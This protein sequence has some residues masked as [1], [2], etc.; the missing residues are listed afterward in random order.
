MNSKSKKPICLNYSTELKNRKVKL[1]PFEELFYYEWLQNPS[2]SDYNIIMDTIVTGKMSEE[3]VRESFYK[4]ITDHFVFCSNPINEEDGFYWKL[5]DPLIPEMD[6]YHHNL[7]DLEI[8][9]IVST[10]FNIEKDQLIKLNVIKI[11]EGRYR[12][13]FVISHLVIDGIKTHETY[14]KWIGNFNYKEYYVPT[15]QEQADLHDQ[16]N[17][18]FSNILKKN[19][20]KIHDFWKQHLEDVA[21]IDLAFLKSNSIKTPAIRRQISEFIF[22]Y[23]ETVVE[24]LKSLRHTYK[25]TPYIFGQ[26]VLAVLLNKITGQKNIGISYPI[27]VLEG[28][29]LIYGAHVNTLIIDYRFNENTNIAS[30]IEYALNFFK[31][32]K[33]TKA[34][35]LPIQEIAQYATNLGILELGFAQTFL[36]DYVIDLEGLTFERVNHEFQVDL[37][38]KLLF[39]QEQ[40]ENRLNY[41]VKY[42]KDVLDEHLVMNFV[43][44]Y[45]NLFDNMLEDLLNKRGEKDINSYQ[46][47]DNKEYNQ[48]IHS[49]NQTRK[50]YSKEKSLHELFEEQVN[51]Y[52]DNT[53]LIYGNKTLT[54]R[55]LNEQANRLAHYLQSTYQ[56]IPDDLI[57]LCL[58][59]SEYMLIS[60][61][62]I[63]KS[64]AGYIPIEPSMPD[65]RITY[66]LEDAKVKVL[67]TDLN[68][69]KRLN[70]L[71]SNVI[72]I[73]NELFIES[74]ELLYSATNP[75]TTVSSNNIAYVIYTSGTTGKPKGVI[76]EHRNVNR[77]IINANYVA[78]DTT[79][80]ILS[81]SGYQFDGSIYDFFAPLLNGASLVISTK[82]VFLDLNELN[83]LIIDNKVTNFLITT[84]L[85]NSIVDANLSGI[86][87]LKYLLFGGEKVSINHVVKFKENFSNVNLV[88]VYGPTEATTYATGYLV[89]SN[90]NSCYTVP[91]GYPISNTSCYV[92]DENLDPLPVGA[93]GELYIGGAGVARG[94]LNR[95]DLTQER[96]LKNPFQTKEEEQE[97]YNARIY[98]TGDL[99]RYL[100]DGAIEYVGRNDFQIKIRGFRI[101]LG[102]IENYLV[103]IPDITQAIVIAKEHPSGTKYLVAYYVSEQEIDETVIR[104]YLKKNLPEYMIPAVIKHMTELPVNING[105]IDRKALPEV[106]F[107]NKATYK[108]P[109]NKLE[110][111]LCQIYGELLELKP[112]TISVEDDFYKLGGN[113][114]MAIKL[115][116]KIN[117]ELSQ[118]IHVTS[119]FTYKTIRQLAK[120]IQQDYGQAINITSRQVRNPEEQLLS[121]AQERLWFIES[122]ESGSNAY[123]I[124][125]H[126]ELKENT[127]IPHLEKAIRKVIHRHEVLRSYI[128]TGTDG[129]GYQQIIDDESNPISI[130]HKEVESTTQLETYMAEVANKIFDLEKEYPICIEFYYKNKAKQYM[131][132]VVHHIAFDGWSGEIFLKEVC[133]YYNYYTKKQ[134]DLTELPEQSIQYKDFAL[135]Q[136]SYLQ[137]E[138]LGQQLQFW[139]E[140]LAGYE[141]L[142]LPVDKIRPT[143]LDYQGS[144]IYFTLE[145]D[146][147]QKLREKAKELNVSMYSMLLGGYYLLLSAYSN[148]KDI[149]L[150]T[151]IA[152]R[153]YPEIAE[154]IGFF[155]NTLAIRQQIEDMETIASFIRKIGKSMDIAQEN[156]DL[157]F[158]KLVEELGVEKDLSRHPVF[159]VMF[160]VQSFGQGQIRQAEELMIP[161]FGSGQEKQ[162]VAKFDITTMID[163][164][165]TCITGSFNYA[166]SIFHP[167]TI[168]QYI[169]TYKE[170]LK[171]FAELS[172]DTIT[173]SQI[174]L[175]SIQDFDKIVYQWNDTN[176]PFEEDKTIYQLFEEQAEKTPENIAVIYEDRKL[177]YRQLNEKSNQ[178][179]AYL[180]EKYSI[181]PEDMIGVCLNRSEYMIITILGVLKAGAAYVP[182]DPTMPKERIEYIFED[183]R[184]KAILTDLQNLDYLKTLAIPSEAINDIALQQL[185]QNSYS[186]VNLKGNSES[187][188]LAYVIYTSGTTGKPKGVMVE[189]KSVNR[190]IVNTNYVSID[191]T[192]NILSLSG[193]QFDGS[194][195]DFFAPLL[196]GASL[197]ISVKEIFLDF[198]E[199]NKIILENKINNFF[200]TTSLFNSIVEANLPAIKSL[201]YILYGGEK[202]SITHINKFKENYPE[203]KLLNVYG[204]TET[205]TFAT[206]YLVDSIVDNYLNLPIGRPIANTTTY[207]LDKNLHPLPIGAVGELY[208]GGAGV[209]RGYLNRE[210]LTQER[211]IKNPF[212]TEEEKEKGYNSILYKTGDLVRYLENGQIE[213]IGRNDFQVKIR[214]FRIEL[215]EIETCLTGYGVIK[216]AVVLAKEHHSGNKYLVG[217]YVSD[218]EL[219]EV[220]LRSYLEKNLPEFM[221]PTVLIHLTEL[222]VT[223][224]GKVD[225]KALPEPEFISHSTYQAPKNETE[226]QLCKI[227]A[228]VLGL[229]NSTIS[230]EDDFFK[231]G[232]D[233]ISSIQL[234]NRIRQR[235]DVHVEVKDIFTHSTIKSLYNNII[236]KAQKNNQNIRSEQGILSGEFNL[237]P[238]QKWFFNNIQKGLLPAYNHWNQ[239]FILK[240][241][242]LNKELLYASIKKVIEH[243]DSFRLIYQESPDTKDS[244]K[245][246]YN[247]EM[248]DFTIEYLNIENLTAEEIED[249]LT[250]WQA[251]FDITM[252]KIFHIGCLEEQEKEYM[253]IH[254]AMHHLA[255]DAVSWR[256]IKD[257][258]ETIYQ[259]LSNHREEDPDSIPVSTI[260]GEKGSSY[261]QWVESITNYKK[262]EPDELEKE[263]LYWESVIS[264][265]TQSNSLFFKLET[266]QHS[267]TELI[268]NKSTTRLLLQEVNHVCN[269][270][271]NDILLTALSQTLTEFTGSP[272]HHILLEGHGREN[273]FSD[274]NINNTV[275]WFTSMYPVKIGYKQENSIAALSFIKDTL[276]QIPNKGI[277]YGALFGYADRELPTVCFNYLG[278]FDTIEVENGMQW[279]FTHENSGISIATENKDS[280]ALNIN[281]GIIDNQLLF[282][283]SGYLSTENLNIITSTFEKNLISLVQCLAAENRSYLTVADTEFIISPDYLKQIQQKNEIENIYLANSLQEGFIYHATSQGEVDDAYRVHLLWDYFNPLEVEVLKSAWQLAQQKFE[284]LRLRFA[285]DE[286]L[287]QIVDKKGQ[288][289]WFYQDI[290]SLSHNEKQ[291]F[292]NN[293]VEENRALP[294][295]LQEGS[296]F[297][298]HLIKQSENHYSALFSNH[299]AILDGWS[300]MILL[301]YVHETY[302]KLIKNQPVDAQCDNIYSISQK[303]LQSH[304][305]ENVAYWKQQVNMLDSQEDLSSL[306][307]PEL[308]AKI[309]LSEYKHIKQP[310]EKAICIDNENYQKIKSICNENGF[311]INALL[312]YC[313][314]RQLNIYSASE[315]T[316]VGTVVSGRNLSVDGIEQSVGLYINTLPVIVDH[317]PQSVIEKIRQVQNQ[318][319]EANGKSDISLAILQKEGKR[320]FNTLFVFENY[321]V[322]RSKESDEIFKI[323]LAKSIEKLDYPLGITVYEREGEIHF[324]IRYA[325]ELF[326]D[327]IID[328]LLDGITISIKEIITKGDESTNNLTHLSPNQY[329]NIVQNWNNTRQPF[330]ANKTINQLFEEQVKR[331]PDNIAVVYED[332]ALTYQELNTKANQLGAYLKQQYQI[333]PDDLIVLCLDRSYKMLISMLA[334]MKSGAAYVPVS[335]EYP[336]E[337]IGFVL[338]DTRAKVIITNAD[339]QER[340][341]NLNPE[342]SILLIE[343]EDIWESYSPANFETSLRPDNLAYVIYTSGT[344]GRPKGVLIEHRNLVHLTHYQGNEFELRNG[345]Q[346]N[347]LWYANY[348]FDA[349]IW[350]LYVNLIFG[351]STFIVPE[352][353]R[354]DLNLLEQ[355]IAEN[356]IYLA[357]IPPVLLNTTTILKLNT[358]VVA[359]EV[360]NPEVMNAYNQHGVKII[361]AYGP[362]ETT[363]CG[364][365]HVFKHGDSNTNIGRPISNTSCYVLDKTLNPLPVGAIGELYIG[366]A[367]VARGYL[368]REELTQERFL[369]N[370]FQTQEEEQEGYNDRIYKTGDLVRYLPDGSIEY[371]GRNDFQVKIRGFRIELGEIENC[372]TAIPDITQATVIAKEHPSGTKF[373]VGYYVSEQEKDEV[374]IREHMEKN[375]PEYMVPAVIMHLTEMPVTI[376]GKLDRK[377]LPEVEFTNKATYKAP[378]NKLEEELC[379]IYAGLLELKPDTISV[380]DDFYKL[381]GNS[382]LAIKLVSRINKE[383]SQNIHVTAVFTHKTIR[384]LARHIQLDQ[385][386]TV[387]ITHK[388]VE[389]PEEQLL[390]FA[391]ERLWFIESFEG[392]SNAY[393]IPIHF[394]LQKDTEIHHLIQAIRKVVHRHEV[395]RSYIWTGTEGT[396]YQLVVD[397][398]NQPLII[399]R[400]EVKD[401][402]QLEAYM[403]E[404]TNRI[405]DLE[406]EY[407]IHIE[408][409]YSKNGKRYLTIVVHH[410]AFDGWSAEVFM[411]EVCHYYNYY[412]HTQKGL[413]ELP[414]VSIQYKDFALWQRNYLQGEILEQQLQFWKKQLEGYET[415]HL[416]TDKT[417]PSQTDYSGSEI[418]FTLEEGIS[419]KLRDK[420]KELNVSMYSLLL[421]GYYLLLSAYSNQKDI[422]IGSP[423]AGRHYPEIT[424]TIGFFVNTL[425]IRQQ[426]DDK[427]AISEFIRRIGK[428][429]DRAQ[430]N[431]DLPFE[432]LV[433]ELDVEKDLSRHPIF[434]VMFSVQSFGQGQLGQAEELMAPYQGSG[435]EKQQVAKFDLTTMIDDAQACIQGSFNYATSLF[436]P[437]TIE[438][439][440]ETYKEILRQFAELSLESITTREISFLNKQE[441]E[442]IIHQWNETDKP[443]KKEKTIH[444]MFEEQVE[445]TPEN[446]AVIY[447]GKKLTYRQLN[448]K[449]NQLATYLKD[450]Y[451]I[452]P[453]ELI[454]L[455]LDRSEYMLVAILGVLKAG[456][457]YVPVDP[458]MPKE[459]IEYILHDIHT[460][461]L[462]TNQAYKER[463]EAITQGMEISVVYPDN[464]VFLNEVLAS[465]SVVN[466]PSDVVSTNLAYVI[467]TSG[468]T[469]KPKGAMIEHTSVINRITWMHEQY[470][471]TPADKI[472]QKTTYTFDVSVWELFWANW[473]GAT[474]VF[475]HP[476]DYKDNLYLIDLIKKE[477]ITT[478]HFVP[479]MLAAFEESLS[480]NLH[481]KED[482]TSLRY[483]FCSGEALNLKEVQKFKELVPSCEIHNLYGPTEATVDVLYYDCNDNNLSKVLIGR[484]IYNTTAYI[485][486]QNLRPLPVGASGELYIGGVNVGRGYLNNP[487]LTAERFLPNPFQREEEKNTGSNSRI[488]KTGDVVR[489]QSDGNIEY[490]GRNDFQV[491]IRGFRI[492]LEEIEACMLSHTE[493]RQAIV[494]PRK[495]AAGSLY[496]AGY[497]LSDKELDNESI[498]MH[499]EKTLPEYMVPSVFVHLT[500][501][502][503]TPNGKLDRKALPEPEFTG[504]HQYIAPANDTERQLCE[505]YGEVLGI[506]P[507]TISASDDFYGL[508]GNSI[509]TIR[510][511]H[512]INT[513]L[514]TKIRL[515]DILGPKSIQS[516]STTILKSSSHFKPVV[517]LNN[518]AGK[519][520]MFMVHPGIA[521]CEVYATLSQK[522]EPYYHCKGID[523]YNLYHSD[524]IK[525]LDL[526]AA[527]YLA[528]IDKMKDK[529]S[530]YIFLGWSLGGQIALE[531][532]AQLEARGEKNITVYLL[533]TWMAHIRTA[534]EEDIK[535]F[536]EKFNIPESNRQMILDVMVI[537]DILTQQPLS[538]KLRYTNVVLFKAMENID[539]IYHKQYPYNNIDKYLTSLSQIKRIDMPAG[540]HSLMEQN[541]DLVKHLTQEKTKSLFV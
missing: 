99:V 534:G 503:L 22:R 100:P 110:E 493:I 136:R 151:P 68:N 119:V 343:K 273:I 69:E 137:G 471:I 88:H 148:Q 55:D 97:E 270:E 96:F 268:F 292:I 26:L 436:S 319:N 132:I 167:D 256:I 277:G 241:P 139:K 5:R 518:A 345:L 253:G 170:I 414:E 101:E 416:P 335:P 309:V 499:L 374:S 280:Y 417:R 430:E 180:K 249:K 284:T 166:T 451:Q 397:D 224:N 108:A 114:I 441:F 231:L 6:F 458:N 152:G 208:I 145:E 538:G 213:Y 459:R 371:V 446:I 57:G 51:K 421:G 361:N 13:I 154:T 431:Q 452:R 64:G 36:R 336:D 496:L 445:R 439:Y 402:E 39:E 492:E 423:I 522:L 187:A 316:V 223:I 483:L 43:S 46:L 410:I 168:K 171:Q 264:D 262:S 340:I 56:I 247:A 298:I 107:T 455:C 403:M 353:Y 323:K 406:N 67:L 386:Q 501:I 532:A 304:R 472:L 509:L 157:P 77:L 498:R 294:F 237:L 314:H 21:G 60:I 468:T 98:K 82:E 505:I 8:Y 475:A 45:R 506:D 202:A 296:L 497:Y 269:T 481:L 216:Q 477:G 454:G 112:D 473:Y 182:V 282:Y 117:K 189:H 288:F 429:M 75:E 415:L 258:L 514:Q 48:I 367:G 495:Q 199:L 434:Q 526:L 1:T 18:V 376:N 404:A 236:S 53:A 528:A 378:E 10:P 330:P 272:Y 155:V 368:N 122:F 349:H 487:S 103:N 140:Q 379:Q 450:T 133:H 251:N 257:D 74:L 40:H 358:L 504:K 392:G 243:H 104:E 479:S 332:I 356:N 228:D 352:S 230:T 411:R 279:S 369:K 158:E 382:I 339:Y 355:Y 486:D 474:I 190:L 15:F 517:E 362:T 407:P 387:K 16:L 347:C 302:I 41:R 266:G 303:Y 507:S 66:M 435:Q 350:E 246:I 324:S 160:S 456:A 322:S 466:N 254:F 398:E 131:N 443:F 512:K 12:I 325:S 419:Q 464:E 235:L 219:D 156:Q 449:A 121:F 143:Q 313:W 207:I 536:M 301:N 128:Q 359:G 476:Q 73:N 344:T 457:A 385:R 242:V 185:L 283:V 342:V 181:Q 405:F 229:N 120:H 71:Y 412:T 306:L 24:K 425:A 34:K 138:I 287:V 418:C 123:N 161:Y 463:M 61:L 252:G 193:Y 524:K 27:A 331:T 388:Q 59:R 437:D 125:I 29:D 513:Q 222:P 83:N 192:D 176:R 135:W 20:D 162:Q 395:L 289:N 109:E 448:E 409:Y 453:D 427:E 159:Q 129:K 124:P 150:G 469:G 261:R 177:T 85:F 102:E 183:A 290:S 2:R 204:P 461:V 142:H 118:N 210:E 179:A 116:S 305:H 533:D 480:N 285:W 259:Y 308:K 438:R 65:E 521:G 485:L 381:G 191:E 320:L 399:T 393:N 111:Q 442:Q 364:T 212:Q 226:K 70:S 351:H 234:V 23:D 203:V 500:E 196:N 311:T 175:L 153:H 372:L 165:Q 502:P 360:T 541:D 315:T 178:L 54:Y 275:G 149:I 529:S 227:Y 460:K 523:S 146:V 232:G 93:I 86:S 527:Y 87:S 310:K 281:G 333:Q 113:S 271:I 297:R 260:L 44:M 274:I 7:A 424:E 194:I 511:V 217:Y 334:V 265:I 201:K 115:V 520:T 206:T 462:L 245:Q 375:L 17:D 37:V 38:N 329:T 221:I 126:F 491:K 312:Y 32:V 390:S 401:E 169:E 400:K 337:R 489:Y 373:L 89:R 11:E 484:P 90:V 420:A 72:T 9:K 383:L 173:T 531:M 348:V 78:I 428:T 433:E 516:V 240:V 490:I 211:F 482:V 147:S 141:T 92:L 163:D 263:K 184:V 338:E 52:P 357:T 540:H 244:Y 220:V 134:N 239:S 365:L 42:D 413:S 76:V 317:Q 318:I 299:H 327:S 62:A 278:Q 49:W 81:L 470:P 478:L 432:K 215:G 4:L 94:Y 276:R 209:A 377:A 293:F 510:L 200:I 354:T 515:T 286:D 422:V 467:Y 172:L 380:E 144:D 465:Y 164:S 248:P 30:L 14:E 370:P 58:D 130:L 80:R 106:E 63:L 307:K 197:T 84:A 19:K 127:D 47:I 205:T 519:S 444:Q 366:G 494:L 28:K 79:D 537:D 426:I 384:Q 50:P 488:Y 391:Q 174:N 295:D 198:K 363:V 447:E 233:S 95:E 530:P 346:R 218:T 188:N 3:R 440:I 326:D 389:N 394:E 341:E 328:Q 186:G 33:T 31:E 408:L 214:G 238:I 250:Q 535:Y 195:Y 300:L 91:I 35:Y 539:S 105:K 255:I 291:I 25:I 525:E 225:Q 508:G 267:Q 396:G 321:P